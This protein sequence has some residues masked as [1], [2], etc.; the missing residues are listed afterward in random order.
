MRNF[1][2]D[3]WRIWLCF[4]LIG[5]LAVI[6]VKITTETEKLTTLDFEKHAITGYVE[7]QVSDRSGNVESFKRFKMKSYVRGMVDLMFVQ[8]R[9]SSWAGSVPDTG[10]TART[11]YPSGPT[12][13]VTATAGTLN[14]GVILGTGTNAVA[15]TDYALQTAIANGSGASQLNYGA[16]SFSATP[17]TSG[18]TRYFSVIRSA[19]NNSG[20]TITVNETGL[21]CENYT[22]ATSYYFMIARDLINGGQAVDNTKTI[23]VTYII[24]ISL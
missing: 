22:G 12:F 9:Y 19:T 17:T 13:R 6:S 3:T 23:T 15:L 2:K 11:I 8:F 16:V 20:N 7:V 24:G 14:T 18:S 21:Y 5:L 4:G 1:I 10:N